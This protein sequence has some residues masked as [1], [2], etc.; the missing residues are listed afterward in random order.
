[1]VRG[2]LALRPLTPSPS[3]HYTLLRPLALPNSVAMRLEMLDVSR[4]F[5]WADTV[6]ATIEA[7][8]QASLLE[9]WVRGG[10]LLWGLM[11]QEV[12]IHPGGM[13]EMKLSLASCGAGGVWGQTRGV[14]AFGQVS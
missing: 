2:F 8:V 10:C 12:H 5:A 6:R 14:G 4:A 7:N 11:G 13:Y 3:N 1:M 9:Q